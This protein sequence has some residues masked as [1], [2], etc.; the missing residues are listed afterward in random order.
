[1]VLVALLY[2][3]LWTRQYQP[4]SKTI[5]DNGSVNIAEEVFA[6]C[7]RKYTQHEYGK[8][9]FQTSLVACPSNQ[10]D[11]DTGTKL[12]WASTGSRR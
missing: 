9:R 10:A 2:D 12:I 8:R 1:M 11:T 7:S 5:A 6:K 4:E 3:I